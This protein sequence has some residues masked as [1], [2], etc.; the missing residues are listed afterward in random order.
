MILIKHVVD[1]IHHFSNHIR[2]NE[3]RNT[4]F[5]NG[6]KMVDMLLGYADYLYLASG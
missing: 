6:A 1:A 4:Q 5:I 2:A 3:S